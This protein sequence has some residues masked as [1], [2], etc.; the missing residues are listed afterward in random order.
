MN[1]DGARHRY[2]PLDEKVASLVDQLAVAYGKQR[3]PILSLIL[4]EHEDRARCFV[5]AYRLN[6]AT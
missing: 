5:E 6:R 1:G 3:V 2:S 4:T